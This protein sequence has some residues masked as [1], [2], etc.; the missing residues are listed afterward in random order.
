MHQTSDGTAVRIADVLLKYRS[1]EEAP[2]IADRLTAAGVS[3]EELLQALQTL[4]DSLVDAQPAGR[5]E[6]VRNALI[7]GE[8]QAYTSAAYRRAA[9]LR[10]SALTVALHQT[11]L[12]S[13]AAELGVSRQAVFKIVKNKETPAAFPPRLDIKDR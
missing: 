1:A 7:A 6:A 3:G 10:A 2:Q 4:G 12:A 11:T 13:V 5:P 8:V 9:A